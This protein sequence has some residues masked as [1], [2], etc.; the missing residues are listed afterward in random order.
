MYGAETWTLRQ[1][2]RKYLETFEMD[3]QD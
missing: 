3:K 2:D 1:V